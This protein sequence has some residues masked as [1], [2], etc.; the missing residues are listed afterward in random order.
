MGWAWLKRAFGFDDEAP[1]KPIAPLKPTFSLSDEDSL[2]IDP[3]DLRA[4]LAYYEQDLTKSPSD[5]KPS[6][7]DS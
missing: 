5:Q 2:D 3:A 4:V 7:T 1:P 6:K